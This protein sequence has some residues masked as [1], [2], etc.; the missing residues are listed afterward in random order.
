[1][2]SAS[3]TSAALV[4][5]ALVFGVPAAAENPNWLEGG[6]QVIKTAGEAWD[7]KIK[8]VLDGLKKGKPCVE[9]CKRNFNADIDD[10]NKQVSG[11]QCTAGDRALANRAGNLFKHKAESYKALIVF[12]LPPPEC[13]M[14]GTL[15]FA[16]KAALKDKTANAEKGDT[17]GAKGDA[18]GGKT[19]TKGGKSDAKRRR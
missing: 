11:I 16:M 10:I 1:M 15:K 5:A 12:S 6:Q 19:G 7:S 3:I 17:N 4:A 8:P 2:T 18:K 14:G 9:D 13:G